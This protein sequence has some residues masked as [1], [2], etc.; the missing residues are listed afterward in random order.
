MHASVQSRFAPILYV[1]IFFAGFL[2]AQIWFNQKAYTEELPPLLSALSAVALV[3]L[4]WAFVSVRSKAKAEKF[5]REKMIQNESI[6]P[7]CTLLCN[8]WNTSRKCSPCWSK[9]T[10]KAWRNRSGSRRKCCPTTKT[11][12]RLP[13]SW[14]KWICSHWGRTRSP[15]AK[16]MGACSPIFSSCR[17]LWKGA[18]SKGY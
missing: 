3:W 9:T 1:L 13:P 5:Y 6:P 2:T 7:S 8:T 15:R 14:Q 11:R 18:R 17:R 16:P 4:A 10:A 12:A